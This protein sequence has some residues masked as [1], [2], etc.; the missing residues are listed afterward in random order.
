MANGPE[1]DLPRR[2]FESR[3]PPINTAYSGPITNQFSPNT[4]T[5]VYLPTE[6]SPPPG[7][8]SPPSPLTPVTPRIPISNK[9]S[10]AFSENEFSRVS[11][12]IWSLFLRWNKSRYIII[13]CEPGV[14]AY[15]TGKLCENITLNFV[16]FVEFKTQKF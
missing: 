12:W 7:E 16:G 10:S 4:P 5:P 15:C 14:N 1:L 3:P 9:E 2:A 11:F 13:C 8:V 6:L